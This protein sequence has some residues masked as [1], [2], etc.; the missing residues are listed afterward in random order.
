MSWNVNNGRGRRI[1]T[2]RWR[3][4]EE[5]AG[6]G[7]AL[8]LILGICLVPFIPML[9]LGYAIATALLERGVH[10]LFAWSAGISA[11]AATGWLL[12]K[13]SIMRLLYFGGVTC[14][15][16][17]VAYQLCLQST[18]EIWSLFWALIVFAIGAI[19]TWLAFSAGD[20]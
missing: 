17:F 9:A 4:K 8:L 20:N 11:I 16:S 7:M 5:E 10:E 15:G 13:S 1:G 18:D 6:E 19:I 12:W 3:S 2:L 14:F